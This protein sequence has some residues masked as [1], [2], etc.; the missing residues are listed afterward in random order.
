M[1][2]ENNRK[3]LRSLVHEVIVTVT[4]DEAHGA[5][6]GKHIKGNAASDAVEKRIQANPALKTAF[7]NIQTA[8][9]LA[10]ALQSVLDIVTNNGIDRSELEIT[11]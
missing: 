8:P 10:A 7:G 9:G 4:P 1:T 11:L 6:T 3:E 2:R 5:T